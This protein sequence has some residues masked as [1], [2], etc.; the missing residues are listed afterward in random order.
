MSEIRANSITDA[1]GTS[2]PSIFFAII[3]PGHYY[4]A[5]G[6]VATTAELR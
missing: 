2:V 5:T 4:R 1:A 3:P 6:G